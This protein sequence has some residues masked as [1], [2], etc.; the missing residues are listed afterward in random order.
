MLL[1]FDPEAVGELTDELDRWRELLGYRGPLPRSWRGRLR[2]DLES[3]SVAASTSMEGVPVTVDEVRRILAG[4]RPSEVADEDIDLVLGY[5]D[6]MGFVLRRADDANFAWTRELLVTLQDRVLAGKFG[7]GAGRLRTGPAFVVD[8]TTAR[9]IFAPPEASA[10]PDL[11]DEASRIADSWSGHPATLSAWIHVAIAAIHPFSDGN[12]RTARVCASLA[13]YRGGFQLE[14]FTS[15]EEWWGRHLPDYY[16]AFACLGATFD[17][18]SDVTGFV[19]AHMAAQLHQVRALDLRERVEGMI[20]RAVEQLVTDAH[21]PPRVANAIW[22]AFF[23]REVTSRYYRP[24]AEVTPATAAADLGGAV[25]A[26]LLRGEGA[27]RSQH[28][29]A[30]DELVVRV[31]NALGITV[32]GGGEPG[33]AVVSAELARRIAAA[34]ERDRLRD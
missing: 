19:R 26:G 1:P 23:D 18:A 24:L 13:M 33:R 3:E 17:P 15:L 6:A 2:R 22:D 29:V 12:G 9:E 21:L 25:A 14:E 20:W 32:E 31:G 30:G 16:G 8:R 34:A 7:A 28:Y 11:V 10:V 5:R 4:E 27:G